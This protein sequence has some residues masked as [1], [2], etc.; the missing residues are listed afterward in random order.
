MIT[1]TIK[2]KNKICS[3]FEIKED[4]LIVAHGILSNREDDPTWQDKIMLLG[5][6]IKVG[7]YNHHYGNSRYIALKKI[8][9]KLYDKK[10]RVPISELPVTNLSR[11]TILRW[12]ATLKVCLILDPSTVW[13]IPDQDIISIRNM[14]LEIGIQNEEGYEYHS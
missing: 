4:D 2:A 14:I 3:S 10:V 13:N 7:T 8:A 11:Q 6:I 5:R 9:R 1:V 12:R